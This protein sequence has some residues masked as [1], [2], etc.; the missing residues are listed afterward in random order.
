MIKASSCLLLIQYGVKLSDM[1][2]CTTS[3]NEND[4]IMCLVT[5]EGNKKI[6]LINLKSKE[7]TVYETLA[8][9]IKMNNFKNILALKNK[10]SIQVIGIGEKKNIIVL[11]MPFEVE[12][13]NWID[14]NILVFICIDNIYYFN[15]YNSNR[16]FMTIL[17]NDTLKGYIIVDH[18][19]NKSTNYYYIVGLKQDINKVYGKII[20]TNQKNTQCFDGTA[21]C[22]FKYKKTNLSSFETFFA[23]IN[24]NT[25]GCYIKIIQL[26]NSSEESINKEICQIKVVFSLFEL[27][28]SDIPKALYFCEILGIFYIVTREGK[29]IAYQYDLKKEI[30]RKELTKKLVIASFFNRKN[31]AIMIFVN[32]G[33]LYKIYVENVLPIHVSCSDID[34][35]AIS[36]VF[37]NSLNLNTSSY[38]ENIETKFEKLISSKNYIEAGRIV[39]NDRSDK[40]RNINIMTK[41]LNFKTTD[42]ISESFEMCMKCLMN[43]TSLNFQETQ[44][45]IQYLICTENKLLIDECIRKGKI[46]FTDEI[47]NDLLP[48]YPDLAIKVFAN[49]GSFMTVIEYLLYINDDKELKLFM[50]NY[51]LNSLFMDMFNSLILSNPD[52]ALKFIFFLIDE[53]SESTKIEILEIVTN[54]FVKNSYFD[55]AVQCLLGNLKNDS[56]KESELQYKLIILCLKYYPTIAENIFKTQKYTFYNKEKIANI[57][58]KMGLPHLALYNVKN[59]DKICD[60]F[61]QIKLDDYEILEYLSIDTMIS[62]VKKL[63]EN[64]E[65]Y[66]VAYNIVNHYHQ[67]SGDE[68]FLKLIGISKETETTYGN[69]LVSPTISINDNYENSLYPS[70]DKDCFNNNFNLNSD[71]INYTSISKNHLTNTNSQTKSN[72]N[73]LSTNIST[74]SSLMT[75][76]HFLINNIPK[77]NDEINND[78]Y[79]NQPIKC[80]TNDLEKNKKSFNNYSD[81]EIFNEIKINESKDESTVDDCITSKNTFILPNNISLE[82]ESNIKDVNNTNVLTSHIQ[83]S[84]LSNNELLL[85]EIRNGIKLKKVPNERINKK[86]VITNDSKNDINSILKSGLESRR[87]YLL[88]DDD[89]E[90]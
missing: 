79:L 15:I 32:D 19:Y 55:Q 76:P 71:E 68:R 23:Y 29:I 33:Y 30:G 49:A 7:K 50:K 73:N 80:S 22:F 56:Q 3:I 88:E 54:I 25:T 61:Q 34:Y 35:K 65:T 82:V 77:Q 1:S 62:C 9:S 60:L 72:F 6:I 24:K 83:L 37:K 2:W 10:S 13:W 16:P 64:K 59:I 5:E 70:L 14:E 43:R 47:G 78:N 58:E 69:G 46:E 45:Y 4:Y 74:N 38:M 17:R 81:S 12:Y 84:P 20:L 85:T 87:K 26:T 27:K 89:E 42:Q 86:E 31:N 48:Y 67:I 53:Y 51:N 52:S 63:I 57:C 39:G 41:L 66:M 36:N 40:L 11:N 44:L 8:D 75:I 28:S 21:G 18:N 90:W